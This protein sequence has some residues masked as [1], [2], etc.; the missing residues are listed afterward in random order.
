[1]GLKVGGIFYKLIKIEE[2]TF[3]YIYATYK[4]APEFWRNKENT[5]RPTNKQRR[6]PDHQIIS[7]DLIFNNL[8]KTNTD[9]QTAKRARLLPQSKQPPVD[10]IHME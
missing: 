8:C 5:S 6:E 2:T 1:M 10:T 7:N 9:R 3:D 4:K